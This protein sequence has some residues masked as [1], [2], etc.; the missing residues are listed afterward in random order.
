VPIKRHPATLLPSW[1]AAHQL[2]QIVGGMDDI[3]IGKPE[4]FRPTSFMKNGG[5]GVNHCLAAM[6]P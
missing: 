2:A 3:G 6:A 4:K 5:G 1:G